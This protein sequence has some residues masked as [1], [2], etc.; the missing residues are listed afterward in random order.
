MEV[1][2]T[3]ANE[4]VQSVVKGFSLGVLKELLLK[5]KT[6]CTATRSRIKRCISEIDEVSKR[7]I[8]QDNQNAHLKTEVESM[9]KRR[10]ELNEDITSTN[11]YL[12]DLTKTNCDFIKEKVVNPAEEGINVA[13][14]SIDCFREII[15]SSYKLN[16]LFK[17]SHPERKD[18]EQQVN[19]P[20]KEENMSEEDTRVLEETLSL[21]KELFHRQDVLRDCKS[22]ARGNKSTKG[23]FISMSRSEWEEKKMLVQRLVEEYNDLEKELA[24]YD[25]PSAIP[26]VNL[27]MNSDGTYSLPSGSAV[28]SFQADYAP[29]AP[30]AVHVGDEEMPYQPTFGNYSAGYE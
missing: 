7:I 29:A 9:K 24:S 21:E 17:R 22:I 11:Q 6:D 27:Q 10:D 5:C 26:A 28:D 23:Y 30:H 14:E 1:G 15:D 8:Q 18:A 3:A 19:W 13:K 16:M 2:T 25:N 12:D 20:F 4:P